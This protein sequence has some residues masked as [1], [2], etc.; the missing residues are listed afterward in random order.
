MAY[1]N[2]KLVKQA[3]IISHKFIFILLLPRSQFYDHKK[4]GSFDMVSTSK[5][6]ICKMFGLNT[7]KLNHLLNYTIQTDASIYWQATQKS[8]CKENSTSF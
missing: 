3:K 8:S 7:Y 5:H 1:R 2:S 6:I 4:L